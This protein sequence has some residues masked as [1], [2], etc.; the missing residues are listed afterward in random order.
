MGRF[1]L[2]VIVPMKRCRGDLVG[3]FGLA[4]VFGFRFGM[5][6]RV[7]V[8]VGFA[9]DNLQAIQAWASHVHKT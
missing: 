3:G 9:L 5:N 8:A 7:Q 1:V 4:C 2:G 6:P